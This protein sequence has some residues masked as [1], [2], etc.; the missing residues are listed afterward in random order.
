LDNSLLYWGLYKEEK[1][2]RKEKNPIQ[3]GDKFNRLTILEV[4]NIIKRKSGSSFLCICECG[5]ICY[6]SKNNLKKGNTKSCGCLS[7]DKLRECKGIKA[8]NYKHGLT[9]NKTKSKKYNL[10]QRLLHKFNIPLEFYDKIYKKQMGRCSICNKRE[11]DLSQSFAIDHNHKT[12]KIRG[13]LCKKCN[14]LLG[15]ANDNPKILLSAIKYLR[16]VR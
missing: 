4:T 2:M 11:K 3:I 6:V 16:R 9:I 10:I 8:R 5:K 12:G 1:E 7:I 14:V 15:F 13:L